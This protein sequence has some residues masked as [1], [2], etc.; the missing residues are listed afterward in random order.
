MDLNNLAE[1]ILIQGAQ[2]CINDYKQKMKEWAE[3]QDWKLI[4]KVF[5][6][7]GDGKEYVININGVQFN[8]NDFY[9]FEKEFIDLVAKFRI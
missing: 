7:C 3:S 4:E 8:I 2:K 5:Q 9:D 1:Q 6:C